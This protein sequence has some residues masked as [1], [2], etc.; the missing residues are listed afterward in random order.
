MHLEGHEPFDNLQTVDVG[1]CVS[2][3]EYNGV[4]HLSSMH[5]FSTQEF[6]LLTTSRRPS[7]F[8]F[9]PLLLPRPRSCSI[10]R[11]HIFPSSTMTLHPRNLLTIGALAFV[12]SQVA[13]RFLLLF[14]ILAVNLCSGLED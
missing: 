4:H 9:A 12:V 13:E 3:A 11:G 8:F 14:L 7:A 6:I 1:I 10:L 2:L 5:A